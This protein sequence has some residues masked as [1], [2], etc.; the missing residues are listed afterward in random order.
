MKELFNANLERTLNVVNNTCR[1]VL[2]TD[3]LPSHSTPPRKTSGYYFIRED[4]ERGV[5]SYLRNA[6]QVKQWEKK[7]MHWNKKY[8]GSEIILHPVAERVKD[9]PSL[10]S[11]TY[12]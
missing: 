4:M 12:S 9:S 11:H 6:N 3:T 7:Q 5:R 1:N 10:P 8:S 2:C